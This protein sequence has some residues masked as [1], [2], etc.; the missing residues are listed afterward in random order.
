MTQN[1]ERN[2]TMLEIGQTYPKPELSRIFGTRDKQGLD[3]K[4]TRYGIVFDVCGRGERAAYT[5]TAITDP[6]K[7]FAITHTTQ[8]S[9]SV[10][11]SNWRARRLSA[12]TSLESTIPS[13]LQT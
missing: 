9:T 8:S 1:R 2:T 3:R 10:E 6:F 12:I 13:G 5:I 4:L 7:V 11:S